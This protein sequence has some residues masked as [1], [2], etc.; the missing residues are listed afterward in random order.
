ML[1]GMKSPGQGHGHPF[2][3]SGKRESIVQNQRI[4]FHILNTRSKAWNVV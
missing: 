3:A 2:S 1:Q 4:L